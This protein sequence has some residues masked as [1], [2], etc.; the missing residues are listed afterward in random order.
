MLKTIL[1]ALDGSHYSDCA[2]RHALA[3]AR[4]HGA[5]VKGMGVVDIGGIERAS[6]YVPLGGTYYKKHLDDVREEKARQRVLELLDEFEGKAK[7]A[8]VEVERYMEVGTPFDHVYHTSIFSDIVVLGLRTYLAFGSGDD[9]GGTL[10]KIVR[11]T[12]RPV[13][14]VPQSYREVESI[15]VATDFS[16]ACARLTY[17]LMHVPIFPSAEI[18]YLAI[19]EDAEEMEHARKLAEQGEKFIRHHGVNLVEFAV[20]EG[21]PKEDILPYAMESGSDLIA[22]GVHSKRNFHDRIFGSTLDHLIEKSGVPL[23]MYQ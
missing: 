4:Q 5:S 19:V 16:P 17:F 20:R 18:R 14:A 1:V 9:G 12:V 23:L 8:D 7:Q 3:L 11:E 2:T 15:L 21:E 13:L 22:L 6:T 10:K